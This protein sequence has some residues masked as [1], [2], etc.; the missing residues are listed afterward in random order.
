[1]QVG[2]QA[3][4]SSTDHLVTV[5]EARLTRVT[6]MN[7]VKRKATG[8]APGT[9]SRTEAQPEHATKDVDESGDREKHLQSS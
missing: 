9:N 2:H 7:E 8:I 5:Q 1:M 6:S 4:S 3:E